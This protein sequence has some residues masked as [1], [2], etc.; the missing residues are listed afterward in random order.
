MSRRI[1]KNNSLEDHYSCRIDKNTGLEASRSRRIDKTSSFEAPQ[2]ATAGSEVA[3]EVYPGP[4]KHIISTWLLLLFKYNPEDQSLSMFS[5]PVLVERIY[6]PWGLKGLGGFIKY[7]RNIQTKKSSKQNQA[8][9]GREAPHFVD[10][11][12]FGRFLR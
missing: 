9:T 8:K 11:G 1:D 6:T 4:P 3:S 7:L 2:S 5:I 12:V 10:E